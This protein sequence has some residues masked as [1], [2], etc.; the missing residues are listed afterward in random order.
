MK[1]IEGLSVYEAEREIRE[2][3]E[4]IWMSSP[5]KPKLKSTTPTKEELDE[6]SEEMK[7]YEEEKVKF[8]T[9]RASY[10]EESQRLYDELVHKIKEDSGLF[11]IPQE[12]QDNVYWYAYQLGHSSGYGEVYG[13][14]MDIVN[15]IFKK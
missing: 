9:L 5:K 2:Y 13:Y 1:T 10:N 4:D 15:Q 7:K 11:D 12:Y 14:L 3:L 6:Y 8:E